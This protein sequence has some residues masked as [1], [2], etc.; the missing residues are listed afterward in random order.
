MRGIA[1]RI[2]G[3]V[4]LPRARRRLFLQAWALLP[5]VWAGL[6]VL[7]F[8]RMG[9]LVERSAPRRA[10]PSPPPTDLATEVAEAVR[11]ASAHVPVPVN[12]L[13]GSMVLCW[14]LRR[15][16]VIA[17]LRFGVRRTSGRIEAHAWVEHD[18]VVLNDHPDVVRHYQPFAE[19]IAVSARDWR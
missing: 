12:C 6:R 17:D 2:R 18:R 8:R 19:P 15:R 5:V 4:R 13:L 3:F 9:R 11:L 16:G 1:R 10:A 14:L 7:G